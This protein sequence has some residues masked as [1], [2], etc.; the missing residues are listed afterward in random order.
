MTIQRKQQ[1][2]GRLI[3]RYGIEMEVIITGEEMSELF[4]ELSKAVRYAKDHTGQVLP[5]G[6][7]ENIAGEMA[8]VFIKIDQMMLLY[9]I[10]AGKVETLKEE[11]LERLWEENR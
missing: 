10:S 2:L 7:R 4:K 9:G 5:E 11:K 3:D 1:I 8:D 6:F